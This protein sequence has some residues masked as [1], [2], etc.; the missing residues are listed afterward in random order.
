MI[1]IERPHVV[2]GCLYPVYSFISLTV[3]IP[4]QIVNTLLFIISQLTHITTDLMMEHYNET[5]TVLEAY[6]KS[7]KDIKGKLEGDYQHEGVKWMLYR[8]L[9]FNC[10]KGGILADD[11]GLGK[12]MQAIATMRGNPQTTLIITIV[13]TVGQWRDALIEFGGYRPIIVNPS[14]TGILPDDIDVVLTTYS[15]FQKKKTTECFGAVSWGRIILDEGHKIRNATGKGHQEIAR[16]NADIRWILSGTPIQNSV[17]DITTLSGWIGHSHT[18]TDETISTILLRRTQEQQAKRNET[19]AL[20]TLTTQQVHLEFET[21]DERK[22]YDKVQTYYIERT[23]NKNDA[24]ETIIRCRQAAT[25]PLIFLQSLEKKTTNRK[26][27]IVE[28]NE[29]PT[30]MPISTTKFSYIIEDIKKV[31]TETKE[32]CLIFCTWTNEM[33][34]IQKELKSNGISSLIYDGKISQANKEAVIYNFQWTTI[35]VLI[36]QITCGN[37][38]LNLQCASRVYI[39]SP[40]WNP[41]VELQA[42]GRAYR[43]GQKKEVKCIRLLMKDTIEDRCGDIQMNKLDLIS[44]A[45]SDD[46]MMN[47]L[48]PPQTAIQSASS[49]NVVHNSQNNKNKYID[50]DDEDM[51]DVNL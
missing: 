40:H 2:T 50:D 17:K 18:D 12:T 31:Q 43:K 8:E 6:N 19:L 51:P 41:C 9:S 7:V 33:K 35:P 45:M 36:L 14:F 38:G 29:L 25:H 16:L 49:S 1:M 13:G 37:A 48:M 10:G 4:Y 22:F 30:S 24:M 26:R 32:K 39:M 34:L 20:P 28:E 11:M 15:C 47:R 3:Y 21:D 5:P 27:K 42:I 44:S 23:T 46:S